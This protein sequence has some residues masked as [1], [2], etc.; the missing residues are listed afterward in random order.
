MG[1]CFDPLLEYLPMQTNSSWTLQSRLRNR[2]SRCCFG[3]L[4]AFIV[5][6]PSAIA[7][8]YLVTFKFATEETLSTIQDWFVIG[9]V[10][11][12]AILIIASSVCFWLAA[13]TIARPSRNSS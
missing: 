5:W 3:F 13:R 8:H 11:I 1:P 7:S 9:E 10:I 12:P 2:A 6:T 4:V